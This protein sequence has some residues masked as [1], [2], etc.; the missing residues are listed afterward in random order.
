MQSS[1][2]MVKCG[3]FAT[4]RVAT[5]TAWSKFPASTASIAGSDNVTEQQAKQILDSHSI[6]TRYYNG[7]LQALDVWR[8]QLPN[9][10]WV[11]EDAWRNVELTTTWLMNFLNY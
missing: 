3:W 9:G 11:N 2:K 7:K 6:E 5:T 8:R 4:V 10:H 1:S